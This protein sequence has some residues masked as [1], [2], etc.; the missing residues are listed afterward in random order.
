MGRYFLA[1]RDRYEYERRAAWSFCS[2]PYKDGW[3][4]LFNKNALKTTFVRVIEPCATR[5]GW[6][7]ETTKD[8]PVDPYFQ[9]VLRP[10]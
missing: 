10:L 8:N 3:F 9:S 4:R 2:D 5:H 6:V 7:V 1:E